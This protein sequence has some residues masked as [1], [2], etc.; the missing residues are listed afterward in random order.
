MLSSSERL[1]LASRGKRIR[2]STP[3]ADLLEV[4]RTHALATGWQYRCVIFE[5]MTDSTKAK[6]RGVHVSFAS[7]DGFVVVVM[8]TCQPG[9]SRFHVVCTRPARNLPLQLG[10][11]RPRHIWLEACGCRFFAPGDFLANKLV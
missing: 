11:T 10:T 6:K 3:I 1:G 5:T 8:E 7:E 4:S 9:E 2:V